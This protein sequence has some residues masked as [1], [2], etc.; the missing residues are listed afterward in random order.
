MWIARPI[1]AGALVC[2]AA[3]GGGGGGSGVTI[4][5]I[6]PAPTGVQATA[7]DGQVTISWTAAA[8]AAS[9]DIYWSTS[10]GVTKASGTRISAAAAPYVATGLTDGA[11][12]YYVVTAVNQAG[13]SAESSQVSAIPVGADTCVATTPATLLQCAADVQA[14]ARSVIEIEGALLCSG[15]GACQVSINGMPVTIRGA[16]GASIRRTDHHDYPLL[17]VV[18]SSH[19]AI[20][21]LVIDEDADVSCSPVSPTNPPVE[22]PSCGRSIDLYGVADVSL[23]HLTIASS[24]S[25]A[26]FLNTCGNASVSH[27]RF[28]SSYLFGLEIT[29]L[30]GTLLVQDSLFWHSASNGLVLFDAHGTSQ[31]PLLITRNLFEHNNRADVYYMCGPQGNALCSAGQLLINDKVDFLRVEKSVIRFGSSDIS[32]NPPIGGVE[33][34]TSGI[35]DLT[36]AGNDIHTHGMWGV[37]LDSNPTDVARISFVDNK[38][39]DN[40]RDPAYLGVD[41]GNFPNGVMTESG[42]CHS[43]VC[44]TVPVGA[45]WALPDGAVSWVTNDLANPTVAVNGTLAATAANGQI[46]AASG[47]TVVLSDGSTEIDRLT[48]P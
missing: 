30:T 22:N 6:P 36:F 15:A 9:Y 12:Y 35:H 44:T 46:T 21:N 47:A 14:G 7:G 38:L 13:E 42:D 16:V 2:L 33:I 32:G 3:C 31:A 17:Q 8:G 26:A 20:S 23:D 24:K 34:N 37:T 10:A 4:R 28:V 45:L 41:I 29:G 43:A 25:V 11:T 1:A 40:G 48:V 19:A 27:V 18:N 39:Y 5:T